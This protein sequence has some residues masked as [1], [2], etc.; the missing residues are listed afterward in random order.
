MI[1]PGHAGREVMNSRRAVRPTPVLFVPLD[2]LADTFA[3]VTA[4]L[5]ADQV[6]GFRDIGVSV[7]GVA[8]AGLGILDIE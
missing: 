1:S 6:Y 8:I 2:E 7:F 3:D 5:V 4:R